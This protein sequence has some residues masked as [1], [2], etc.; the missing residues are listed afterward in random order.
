MITAGICLPALEYFGG[1]LASSKV[2]NDVGSV[3]LNDVSGDPTVEATNILGADTIEQIFDVLV[4]ARNVWLDGVIM[5]GID[6]VDYDPGGRITLV[7]VSR[8]EEVD[9]R[10]TVIRNWN[11][12]LIQTLRLKNHVFCVH[13]SSEQSFSS[14]SDQPSFGVSGFEEVD[15]EVDAIASV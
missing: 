7:R 1:S 5:K 4:H 8:R 11:F 10:R 14:S 9:R 3:V 2:H 15:D 12:E 6:V 13:E